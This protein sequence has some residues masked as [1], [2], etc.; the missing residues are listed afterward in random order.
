GAVAPVLRRGEDRIINDI[1]CNAAYPSININ[2]NYHV[3]FGD[4][5]ISA[6]GLD[7]GGPLICR[8][9]EG[10][11]APTVA[12]VSSFNDISCSSGPSVYT[13]V[14]SYLAWICSITQSC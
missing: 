8:E 9:P 4:G 11:Q 5:Q 10:A 2:Y 13:R 14:S 7:E 3:C 12:G 1:D 6:C